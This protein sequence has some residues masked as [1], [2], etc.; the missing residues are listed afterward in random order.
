MM[1]RL[2]TLYFLLFPLFVFANVVHVGAEVLFEK[3][4]PALLKGKRVGLITNQSAVNRKLQTTYELLKSHDKEY[5]LRAVF[6]PEHGYYGNAHANEIEDHQKIDGIPLYSLHGEHRRPTK[7]MLTGIDLLIYDIQDIGSRSYTFIS[8]L[9]YSLIKLI[10][11]EHH[12]Q[13]E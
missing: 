1:K 12:L 10:R 9:F 3:G 7:E 2:F 13:T 5:Q 6:A 11:P 4:V 8:T